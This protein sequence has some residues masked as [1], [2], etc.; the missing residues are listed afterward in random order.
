[1]ANKN[2][3]NKFKKGNRV[4]T[5]NKGTQ[6]RGTAI[7]KLLAD[8]ASIGAKY[9]NAAEFRELIY[10]AWYE[11][12]THPNKQTRINTGIKLG[13]YVDSKKKI[14]DAG[15]GL[16]K[17]L[18]VHRPLESIINHGQTAIPFTPE[19]RP[20]SKQIK[21]VINKLKNNKLKNTKVKK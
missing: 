21:D 10:H 11:G 20:S 15:E 18:E 9:G 13:D 4:A 3:V 6:K 14:V 19:K 7:K 16:Q 5:K 1:M 17:I 12:L 8:A 2:P